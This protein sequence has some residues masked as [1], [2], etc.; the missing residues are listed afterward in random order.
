[1][2]LACTGD[3]LIISMFLA[4]LLS[5][6]YGVWSMHQMFVLNKVDNTV[7]FLVVRPSIPERLPTHRL[8]AVGMVS[9]QFGRY[10]LHRHVP[11]LKNSES[12][13][14]GLAYPQCLGCIREHCH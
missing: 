5:G 1:V 9:I 12:F 3:L 13:Q 8:G 11:D 7:N 6:G 2:G 14:K 10:M 4:A